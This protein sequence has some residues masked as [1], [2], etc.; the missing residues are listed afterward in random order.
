MR[1]SKKEIQNLH[2]ISDAFKDWEEVRI[3]A[4][5][6]KKGNV[7]CRKY[8]GWKEPREIARLWSELE[9]LGIEVGMITGS[10]DS[11][12]PG[13]KSWTKDYEWNGKRVINSKLVYSVY[14]GSTGPKDEYLIYL[15]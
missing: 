13:S 5:V 7:I 15:S 3:P 11:T 4:D 9:A 8:S 6:K 1:L 14:E 12:A 10:P 2:R